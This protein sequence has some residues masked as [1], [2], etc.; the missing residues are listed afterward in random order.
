[1]SDITP[2]KL[3]ELYKEKK[4]NKTEFLQR[5]ITIYEFSDSEKTRLECLNSI[6]FI[7]I[8]GEKIFKFL[9]E[10][11]I[12]EINVEI[13]LN[14]MN[15]ILNKF[16]ERAYELSEYLFSSSDSKEFI[17]KIAKNIGERVI[18]LDQVYKKKFSELLN[19]IIIDIFTTEDVRSFEILWG[20]WCYNTPENYW[21]FLLDLKSP[22]GFL[23]FLDYF[24]NNHKIYFWFYKFLIEKFSLDQ[25]II[26]FKNSRFSGRLLYIL[27]YLEEE[28]PPNRFYQIV[29]LFVHNGKELTEA[30]NNEIINI[31]K[32]E[33]QYDLAVILIFRWLENINNDSLKKI[34]ED[35]KLNLIFKLIGLVINNQFD[36]LKHDY[37]I[38]SLLSLLVKISKNIDEN[39]LIQF[40]NPKS[41]RI[42]EVLS[43]T[44]NTFL[45][46]SQ[47]RKKTKTEK[48]F[49]LKY[50][51]TTL[52]FIK[53]LSKYFDIK[54]TNS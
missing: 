42:I 18:T 43:P 49:L 51:T 2:T 10:I 26:F 30:Q 25:W 45:I 19:E 21:N 24:I 9:E 53:I 31:L 44:L 11:V 5:I 14:A 52:E 27:F 29:D 28:Q 17:M 40:I 48:R 16:P 36:F 15:I 37:L 46:N 13:R 39:Y 4:I 23:E 35:T 38:Y 7:S 3:S 6:K 22:V 50:K 1:M 34:L 33:N 54:V 47:K 8:S 41:P 12:S 32:K 20:D